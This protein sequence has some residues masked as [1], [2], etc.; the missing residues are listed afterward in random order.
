MLCVHVAHVFQ[1]GRK[2]GGVVRD[3]SPQRLV[4]LLAV[5]VHEHVVLV[6]HFYRLM[7]LKN[8]SRLDVFEMDFPFLLVLSI[9]GHLFSQIAELG[10]RELFECAHDTFKSLHFTH[11]GVVGDLSMLDS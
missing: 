1:I 4:L 5:P 8:F 2:H 9:S 10:F 7:D 3:L 6:Q 11:Y